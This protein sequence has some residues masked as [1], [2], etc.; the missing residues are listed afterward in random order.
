[1]VGDPSGRSRERDELDSD[2]LEINKAGLRENL[3][4]IFDNGATCFGQDLH[5]S[6]PVK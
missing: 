4:R 5:H 1:M 6:Q 2:L 3:Q